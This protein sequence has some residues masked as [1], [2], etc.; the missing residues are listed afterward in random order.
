MQHCQ[1][2][3]SMAASEPYFLYSVVSRKEKVMDDYSKFFKPEQIETPAKGLIAEAE[4]CLDAFTACFNA[5]DAAG[6]DSHLHFLHV[7]FSGAQKLVWGAPGQLPLDF[8]EKLLASGWRRTLYESKEPILVSADKVHFRII[9]SRR[10]TDDAILSLHENVWFVT[11]VAGKW[12]IALR[13]Y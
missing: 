1:G 8:F 4:T 12:G 9:Y 11:R 7:M 10:D 6:M 5:Q 3:S 2:S 13:S